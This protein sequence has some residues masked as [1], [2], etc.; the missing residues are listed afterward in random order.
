MAGRTTPIKKRSQNAYQKKVNRITAWY[1]RLI[2]LREKE[3]ESNKDREHK[4]KVL[5]KRKELKPL[6]YYL[7]KIK[8]PQGA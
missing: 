3:I 1:E 4:D 7:E 5:R 2:L 6:E 8:K